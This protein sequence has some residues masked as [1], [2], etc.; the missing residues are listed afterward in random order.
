MH[1]KAQPDSRRH[2]ATNLSTAGLFFGRAVFC[3]LS[4]FPYDVLKVD[5]KHFG[6][7]QQGIQGGVPLLLFDKRDGL[8][9]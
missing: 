8:P 7:A 3:D 4:G 5:T 6:D 2:R 9:R 1:P